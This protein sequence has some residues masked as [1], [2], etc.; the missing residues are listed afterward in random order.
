[1]TDTTPPIL[2]AAIGNTRVR[3]GLWSAGEI[4]DA[5]SLAH[6]EFTGS[7]DALGDSATH[8]DLCAVASVDREAESRFSA[9]LRKA[10]PGISVLRVGA[11]I[12]IPLIHNLDDAS[13]LGRDRAL[14]ALAAYER[15][16]QA[17][18]V[19]D[20]GTA[21]TVDFV[22]GE[23][24]FHGGLIAPGLR[25]TLAALHDHT[26]ALPSLEPDEPSTERGPFGKDTAHAMQ[27]GARTAVAGVVRTG[28]ERFADYYDAWP[29]VIATGGDAALL[30]SEGIIE[31][32]VPDLQLLGIGLCVDRAAADARDDA[33]LDG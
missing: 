2:V 17:C 28:V 3:L 6:G 8:A 31:H 9:T 32:F 19:I 23:G 26:D 10:N 27:L 18:A 11:D 20:V 22:D 29:Q 24:T 25:M 7:L 21:V 33:D 5:V 15:A 12:P 14:N 4:T 1:M 30:E 16:Q 13:T